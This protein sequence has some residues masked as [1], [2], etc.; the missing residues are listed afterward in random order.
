MFHSYFVLSALLRVLSECERKERGIDDPGM[1]LN[2]LEVFIY[3]MNM[4]MHLNQ[5]VHIAKPVLNIPNRH[6]IIPLA[7]K[8]QIMQDYAGISI[9]KCTYNS[10]AWIDKLAG[11]F[12]IEEN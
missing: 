9:Q 8:P 1:V 7:I 10:S 6:I 3:Y 2:R 4:L 11:K 5:I 12:I